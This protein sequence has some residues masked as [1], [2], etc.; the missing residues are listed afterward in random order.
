MVLACQLSQGHLGNTRLAQLFIYF[1]AILSV[2]VILVMA[3]RSRRSGKSS[4]RTFTS[5]FLTTLFLVLNCTIVR[6][7]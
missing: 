4:K 7:L 3:V 5:F 2:N 1:G 6:T